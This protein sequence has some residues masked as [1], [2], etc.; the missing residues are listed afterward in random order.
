MK[1]VFRISEDGSE[2][3]S[4]I[5]DEYLGNAILDASNLVKSNI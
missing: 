1:L 5:P 2:I 4:Y 3:N